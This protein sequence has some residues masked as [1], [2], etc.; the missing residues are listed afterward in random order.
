MQR[1]VTQITV[2]REIRTYEPLP[3]PKK[4]QD[5][6]LTADIGGTNTNIGIFRLTQTK[7]VL[8]CSL[9][10]KTHELPSYIIALQ[11]ALKYMQQSADI[12]IKRACIAAA[13]PVTVD[14]SKCALT[15][16]PWR[17]TTQEILTKTTLTSAY[18]INDF[19]SI[20]Y[21]INLLDETNPDDLVLIKKNQ[22]PSNENIPHTKAVIGAGTGLGKCLL[23]YDKHR[24]TYIPHPSEGGHGD[25]P[26]HDENEQKIIT[27]IKQQRKL[28]QP[29][30]YEDLLS[31]DGITSL[32]S[33]LASTKY[34]NQSTSLHHMPLTDDAAA[35]IALQRHTD[36]LCNETFQIFTRFYGRCAKNFVLDTY[37]TG[38]LYIGGGIA[39]KNKDIFSS[40][41][42]LD[43]FE[44]THKQ[45]Q[46]L[47]NTPIYIIVNYNVS[48]YGACYAGLLQSKRN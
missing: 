47:K 45:A 26:I 11:D 7:P 4:Y 12:P 37:A 19:E 5:F 44:N 41:I 38:G 30:S 34:K 23:L 42:F 15:N 36:P 22:R 13:G 18:I 20:A 33:Y 9:H 25:F 2:N 10:Y 31:G 8:L 46:I 28:Q 27:Y 14:H 32:Y 39:A 3:I 6:F 17:I 24:N 35:A 21:G 16:V 1:M 43:E 29:V 40:T 48:L